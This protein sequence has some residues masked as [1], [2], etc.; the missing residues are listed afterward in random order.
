L[1]VERHA[2]FMTTPHSFVPRDHSSA[3]SSARPQR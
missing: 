3:V 2:S 1:D